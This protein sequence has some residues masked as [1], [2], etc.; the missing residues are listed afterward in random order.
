MFQVNYEGQIV[1]AI[2][3]DTKE[4]ALVA[5]KAVKIQYEEQTPIVS[6]QVKKRKIALVAALYKPTKI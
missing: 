4:H 2:L 1:G 6:I 5:S 3:A